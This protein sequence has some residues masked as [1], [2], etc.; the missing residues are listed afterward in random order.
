MTAR[1]LVSIGFAIALL[2]AFGC[3]GGSDSNPPAPAFA[4]TDGGA[5]P[6]N[7]VTLACGGATGGTTE[8]VNAVIGGPA[9]GATTLKGLNF[10]VTYDATKLEF[11]PDA[12]PVSP[13]MP[14]ALVVVALAN[15]LPGRVV[16]G[17]QQ[18][19]TFPDVSV[20]SGQHVVL[21]LSFRRLGT[22]T[23]VPTPLPIEN[24]DATGASATIT[25]ASA[26]ALS[27]Q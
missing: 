8:L 13:L 10:D 25:F 2:A 21:S 6:A 19:G 14:D 11:V 1:R 9:A 17:I 26:L 16:V 12:A 20:G 3:G 4:C 22:T 7:G 5:A 15:G 24:A 27:Y 23:F 18:P